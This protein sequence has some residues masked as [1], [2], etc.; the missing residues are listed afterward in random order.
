M[1]EQASNAIKFIAHFIASKIGKTGLTVTIDVYGPTGSALVTGA[2]ATEVGGGLYSYTLASG[3]TGNEGLY[4]AVFKTADTT[5][6]QQHIPALWCVGVAGVENL[7]ASASTRASATAL[8][9]VAGYIDTEV[10]A[11]KAKTDL[12]S[13]GSIADAV[14][15]EDSAEH[16]SAGTFG[17]LTNAA[18]AA[19]D[20]LLNSVP[21]DYMSGT[22]GAALGRIRAAEISVV[23][24]V[25]SSGDVAIVVGDDYR[26]DDGRALEWQDSNSSW[27]DLAG[28]TVDMLLNG[29][30]YAATLPDGNTVRVE[31]TAAQTGALNV[32]AKRFSIRAL[33]GGHVITLASGYCRV[34]LPEQG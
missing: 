33:I 20:P 26:A 3:S 17:N 18:G 12:L 1:I 15:D 23:S 30:T 16:D 21:G 24:P 28:A 34:G 2:A 27:P 13:P 7:D 25:I 10:A 29:Q 4:A 32:G 19:S 14:W 22:A 9:T 5:V 31:L 11:I 8:A 6:D